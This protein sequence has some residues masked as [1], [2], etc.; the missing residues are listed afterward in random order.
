MVTLLLTPTSN[1]GR[2]GGSQHPDRRK[3]GGHGPNLSDL[4]EHLLPTPRASDGTKGGPNQRGSK[5]DLTLPSAAAR[6]RPT[7]TA[8]DRTVSQ[9]TG[10]LPMPLPGQTRL[11]MDG[12]DPRG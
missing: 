7:P 4:V 5:G 1:L 2:I 11:P 9:R 6:L 8:L 3:A 12:A 10:S